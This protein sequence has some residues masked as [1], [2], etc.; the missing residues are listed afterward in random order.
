M[1]PLVWDGP[2]CTVCAVTLF[3]STAVKGSQSS[4]LLTQSN[5][6]FQL[7]CRSPSHT[8]AYTCVKP[9]ACQRDFNSCLTS[10]HNLSQKEHL[11]YTFPQLWSVTAVMTNVVVICAIST[12]YQPQYQNGTN[13]LSS[14]NKGFW[15]SPQTTTP[16]SRVTAETVE[17]HREI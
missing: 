4:F 8:L 15:V 6:L 16:V 14:R 11:L 12:V 10:Y 9:S 2:C 1:S 13:K 5:D 7:Q 17:S 3:H